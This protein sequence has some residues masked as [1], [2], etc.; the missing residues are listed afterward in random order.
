MLA[1]VFLSVVAYWRV[2]LPSL[3]SSEEK[4]RMRMGFE[5]FGLSSLVN[6]FSREC[7]AATPRNA[8]REDAMM[9]RLNGRRLC[10]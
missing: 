6:V 8:V 3:N 7:W 10:G 5:V 2:G 4:E 9:L 1:H